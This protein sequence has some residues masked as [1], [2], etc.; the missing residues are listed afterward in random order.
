[1]APRLPTLLALA[2]PAVA[3]ASQTPTRD[4]DSNT[5]PGFV[6]F[7]IKRASKTL[8]ARDATV[9]LINEQDT[10]YLIEL[11]FG[12]NA[13]A[14]KIAIDTGSDE[15]FVNP[16]CNDRDFTQQQQ[17]ECT[18]DGKYTPSS[19][20]TSN[21][22]QE[23]SQIVYGSGAV[24]IQYVVDSI[25]IPGASKN[26][27]EVQFGVATESQDLNEG[28]LGLG[29]GQGVNLNY[30]NFVDQ[31]ASQGVT[32]TKAFSV[33]L[34]TSDTAGGNII[35]GGVDTKKFSGS[36]ATST[37]QSP[38]SGDI[39]R[40]STQMNSLTFKSGSTSN[41]YSNSDLS[42]VLDTGSSLCLLPTAI[43]SD[44]AQDFN[45]Q[46]DS[47]GLLVVDCD[48]QNTDG[49]LDFAFDGVTISVPFSQFILSAGSNTCILGVQAVESNS[50]ITALL[51]DTFLRSAYAVFD[52]TNMKISLAQYVEC[53]TNEQAIPTGSDGAS[54]FT[55][56][57]SSS[58][59][60]SSSKSTGELNRPAAATSIVGFVAGIAALMVLF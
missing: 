17:E 31:L 26:M 41:K 42:V 30:S 37:I 51:G 7:P 25:G 52:Q 44:M 43:V 11:T 57:C 20:T 49:S 35:F 14:V 24:N 8:S 27:T 22:T 9:S 39:Q 1:M 10:S 12:S 4:V 2:L 18:S 47:S 58:S 32:N 29:F 50:G 34:G 55:G 15:L 5:S 19:S 16:N 28:I 54:K 53:G 33:A 48:L 23:T 6:S 13:Q 46:Q 40:Y 56:E 36:L 3:A 59:S 21:V 38:A 60:S 45:A